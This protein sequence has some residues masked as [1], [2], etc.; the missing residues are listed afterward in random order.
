[1][2]M[3]KIE[4]FAKTEGIEKQICLTSIEDNWSL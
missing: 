2:R 1:M 3:A 4:K